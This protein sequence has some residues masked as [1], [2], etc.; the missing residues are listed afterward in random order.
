MH[1]NAC[2]SRL[3]ITWSCSSHQHLFRGFGFDSPSSN[4]RDQPAAS[5]RSRIPHSGFS[6]DDPRP[7]NGGSNQTGVPSVLLKGAENSLS[8]ASASP[9]PCHPFLWGWERSHPCND[10]EVTGAGAPDHYRRPWSRALEQESGGL[11]P[12]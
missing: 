4:E 6:S 10:K 1:L 7:Q 8:T 11:S 2:T 3:I 12:D 5:P 9:S